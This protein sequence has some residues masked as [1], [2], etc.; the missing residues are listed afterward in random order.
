MHQPNRRWPFD[1]TLSS[2]F[3]LAT[4]QDCLGHTFGEA[5]AGGEEKKQNQRQDDTGESTQHI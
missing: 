1:V 3:P 5:A 4:F 2:V